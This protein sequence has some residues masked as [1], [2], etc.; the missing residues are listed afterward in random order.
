MIYANDGL[1]KKILRER[2]K[3]KKK[4]L[5]IQRQNVWAFSSQTMLGSGNQKHQNEE[6]TKISIEAYQPIQNMT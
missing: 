4:I 2:E 1:R 6:C 3:L 5:T